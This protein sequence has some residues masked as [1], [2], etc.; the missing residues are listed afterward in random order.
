MLPLRAL[1]LKKVICE[2]LTTKFK[3]IMVIETNQTS[4]LINKITNKQ[5]RVI[6]TLQHNKLSMNDLKSDVSDI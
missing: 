3:L 2:D 1:L 6:E 5:Q 4:T